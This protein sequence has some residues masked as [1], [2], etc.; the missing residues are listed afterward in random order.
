M[1]VGIVFAAILIGEVAFV[2][3]SVPAAVNLPPS[4]VGLTAS[5]GVGLF[6]KYLLPFEITSVLL[7]MAIVGAMSL[8]RRTKNLAP[9]T[10]VVPGAAVL[11]RDVINPLAPPELQPVAVNSINEA[12]QLFGVHGQRDE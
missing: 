4:D 8:A 10:R 3:R 1:P 6:T 5:I 2:L 7:L 11:A 12:E 9:T